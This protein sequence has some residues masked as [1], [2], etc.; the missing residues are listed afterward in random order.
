MNNKFLYN[1]AVEDKN[2]VQLSMVSQL[3]CNSHVEI[4]QMQEGASGILQG[5]CCSTC[6]DCLTP[7]KHGKMQLP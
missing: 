6:I 1:M 3:P 2:P 7:I 5:G 4:L